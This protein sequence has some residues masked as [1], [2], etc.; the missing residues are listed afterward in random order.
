MNLDKSKLV[1]HGSTADI[2]KINDKAIK[3]FKIDYQSILSEDTFA[4]LKSISSPNFMKLDKYKMK[5]INYKKVL[6]YYTYTFIE[7]SK[8]EK[9]LDYFL[10]N[11][12]RLEKLS[13]IFSENRIKLGDLTFENVILQEDNIVLIDPDSYIFSDNLEEIEENN[14]SELTYL[15]IDII[16]NSF[17]KQCVLNNQYFDIYSSPSLTKA[18][19]KVLK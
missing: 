6:E 13:K 12:E 3:V 9:T 2:Y 10:D 16:N 7:E 19:K 18:I 14:R 8:K 1:G 4:F 15:F 11:F 5:Y 17:D